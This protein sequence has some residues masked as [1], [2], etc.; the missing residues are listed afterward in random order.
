MVALAN[1]SSQSAPEAGKAEI[2][3]LRTTVLSIIFHSTLLNH[4]ANNESQQ[5]IDLLEQLSYR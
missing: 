1:I 3:R 5:L 2:F 4:V